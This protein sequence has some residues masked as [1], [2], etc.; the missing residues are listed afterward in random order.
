MGHEGDEECSE[1]ISG[2]SEWFGHSLI[3]QI[4]TENLPCAE[5]G[6]RGSISNWR[7]WIEISASRYSILVEETDN[8]ESKT[9]IHICK[10]C[11]CS[12]ISNSL[13]SMDCSL[14]G[15]S[16]LGIF[17][18]RVLEWI[19]TYY[20]RR[21]SQPRGQTHVSCIGRQILSHWATWESQL[22]TLASLKCLFT[23]KW[24]KSWTW[25]RD[26]TEEYMHESK[27]TAKVLTMISNIFIFILGLHNLVI[28]GDRL[29]SKSTTLT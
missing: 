26:W 20:S 1:M 12:A 8:I 6:S 9:K 15:F 13:P 10:A 18:A 4:F 29:V 3:V 24:A 16:V 27:M 2:V 5:H 22:G 11:T 14:L 28:A 21:A 17:Q 23:G 19:A 7:K 25:L